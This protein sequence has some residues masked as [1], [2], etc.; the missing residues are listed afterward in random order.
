MLNWDGDIN[1]GDNLSDVDESIEGNSGD[2]NVSDT[3]RVK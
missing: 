2:S 1:V 3:D